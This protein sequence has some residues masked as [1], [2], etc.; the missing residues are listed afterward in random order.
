[1]KYVLSMILV[2]VAIPTAAEFDEVRF[3]QE[4]VE[5][6]LEMDSFLSKKLSMPA[7]GK[8]NIEQRF[9]RHVMDEMKFNT[10]VVT[11]ADM[12]GSGLQVVDIAY[13]NQKR[14][15]GWKLLRTYKHWME[16]IEKL[17][18]QQ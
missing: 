14:A 11:D 7:V 15:C 1:M 8:K 6:C 3:Q 18:R 16:M 10:R 4:V 12:G 5:P 9:R 17:E 2:A 13:I